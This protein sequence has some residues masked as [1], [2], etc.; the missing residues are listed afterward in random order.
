[1]TKPQIDVQIAKEL[2]ERARRFIKA[3]INIM[4]TDGVIVYSN[5]AERIGSTDCKAF[6]DCQQTG[7]VET[8]A[9]RNKPVEE[10]TEISVA[11][12]VNDSVIGSIAISS[13]PDQV[14]TLAQ[15]IGSMAELS[16]KESLKN[17]D[18][19]F[20]QARDAIICRRIIA[21]ESLTV[22]E[23]QY[24]QSSMIN[25][26]QFT[27]AVAITISLRKNTSHIITDVITQ[28]KKRIKE[29]IPSSLMTEM[30]DDTI[31]LLMN[32]RTQRKVLDAIIAR[33][34]ESEPDIV[35]RTATGKESSDSA[36]ANLANAWRTAIATLQLARESFQ[37]ELDHSYFNYMLPIMIRNMDTNMAIED[38]LSP[39]K[40][41]VLKD[42]NGALIKTLEGWFRCNNRPQDTA[43]LLHIHRNTLEYRLNLIEKYSEMDLSKVRDRFTLYI[44]LE[45]YKGNSC[46]N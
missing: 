17:H 26:A 27:G 28:L 10:K 33:Y 29:K 35:I 39:F 36:P 34:R 11:L 14:H 37:K 20:S 6:F 13:K 21:S 25:S 2:V 16:F 32:T 23:N 38:I 3:D 18:S 46:T 42:K 31:A 19:S 15:L 22:E 40:K 43:A 12:R 4:N 7:H 30:G 5:I 24:L 9:L 41:I 1:M 8:N 44:A 45:R